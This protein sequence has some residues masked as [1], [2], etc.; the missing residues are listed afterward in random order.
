[1]TDKLTNVLS[2]QYIIIFEYAYFF[3]VIMRAQVNLLYFRTGVF[4]W[5]PQQ[6]IL[7]TIL[8][9]STLWT[10][11]YHRVYKNVALIRIVL[12]GI[13]KKRWN[14][15]ENELHAW[16]KRIWSSRGRGGGGRE[17]SEEFPGNF[18]K[19]TGWSSKGGIMKRQIKFLT[20]NLQVGK[21]SYDHGGST[22]WMSKG[23]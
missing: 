10:S 20:I 6:L 21:L 13:R 17:T 1:M 22:H 5:I 12:E 14:S 9:F 11:E 2:V 19:I 16:G 15:K 3:L 8:F 18:L 23:V 7:L 4:L